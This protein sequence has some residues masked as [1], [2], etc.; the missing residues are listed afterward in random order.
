MSYVSFIELF[1]EARVSF[2]DYFG[3]ET[4][5]T[6]ATMGCF[7]GGIF[8][9]AILD[10]LVHLLDPKHATG[11]QIVP[12]KAEEEQIPEIA[13]DAQSINEHTHLLRA[14]AD[15]PESVTTVSFWKSPIQWL[16]EDWRGFED[17]SMES[18]SLKTTGFVTAL[19]IGIHNFPE[20]LATFVAALSDINVGVSLAFA[21]A[22]HNVPEGISVAMPIYF[23]TGSRT[24]A[25]LWASVS[26]LSEP[27]GA[28]IGWAIVSM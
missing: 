14:I 3:T 25:F 12:E 13:A 20:G 18:H 17:Q 22:I 1:F 5:A 26:G 15:R 4:H 8:L 10:F 27:L 7:F 28:G 16:R 6:L 9:A 2:V 21:I 23:A 24:R 19:A 11:H